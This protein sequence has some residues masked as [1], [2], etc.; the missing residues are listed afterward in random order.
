MLPWPDARWTRNRLSALGTDG[1][2][3]HEDWDKS[4]PQKKR[5]LLDLRGICIYI[6]KYPYIFHSFYLNIYIYISIYLYI[7]I[8]IYIYICIYIYISIYL[9]IYISIYPYIYISIYHY[10]SIYIYI[11]T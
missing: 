2:F 7:Y 9:Y 3:I 11:S 10:I 5:Y 8:Y 4:K 6:S 1:D